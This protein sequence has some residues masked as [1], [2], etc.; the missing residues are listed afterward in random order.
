M[1]YTPYIWT[2]VSNLITLFVVFAIFN[3]VYGSFETIVISL[4][5]LI[6]VGFVNFAGAIGQTKIQ[7]MLLLHEEFKRL[8]KLLKEEQTND[9]IEFEQI[10]VEN[11]KRQMNDVQV[12]FYINVGFNA[13]IAIIAIF[14]LFGVL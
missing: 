5:V 14:N 9:E 7:E 8:R 4:L 6:Y 2:I 12:K 13:V 10:D 11:V 3:A 1:K